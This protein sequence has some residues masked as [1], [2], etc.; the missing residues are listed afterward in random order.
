ML[1]NGISRL[2]FSIC[3]RFDLSFVKGCMNYRVFS[4]IVFTN[5]FYNTFDHDLAIMR[6][7]RLESF[8]N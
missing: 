4:T 6:T 1:V 5:Y 7:D 2:V 8:G 3:I